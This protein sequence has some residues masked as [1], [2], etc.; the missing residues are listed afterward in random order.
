M[1]MGGGAYFIFS[2]KKGGLIREGAYMAVF[3]CDKNVWLP[4]SQEQLS[5]QDGD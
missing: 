2:L 1:H 5:F 4:S 3:F